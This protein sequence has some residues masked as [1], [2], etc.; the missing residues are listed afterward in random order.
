M[1]I[2]VRQLKKVLENVLLNDG[3]MEQVLYEYEF[4]EIMGELLE[5]LIADKDDYLLALTTH[6]NDITGDEDA[7]MVLIEPSGQAHI[8]ELARNKLKEIWEGTYEKNMKQLIPDFAK[9][10][11]EGDIPINGIKAI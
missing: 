3:K 5:T 8:N 4:E 9:Q 7:A 10:L 6:K 1:K 2:T 11:Y